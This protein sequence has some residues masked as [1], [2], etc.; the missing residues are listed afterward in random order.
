MGR[1]RV[2]QPLAFLMDEPLSNLD[3]KL[4]VQMRA[5][6]AQ[7]QR[8]LGTTTIY[9]THD[10]TEAMTLGSRVAVIAGGVLQ[11]IAPP[12]ELYRQPANLFVASFIGS[13]PMNLIDATLERS[14]AG[15]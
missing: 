5:E 14:G 7:L 12:Q 10:Q 9:V 11:Q 8:T 15:A 3:V 1:A 6:I 4:L 2:R 13:P